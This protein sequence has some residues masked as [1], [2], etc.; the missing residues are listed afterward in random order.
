MLLRHG[1]DYS[2]RHVRRAFVISFTR[3]ILVPVLSRAPGL[4]RGPVARRGI[5]LGIVLGWFVLS[6]VLGYV[7][8]CGFVVVVYH[9]GIAFVSGRVARRGTGLSIALGWFVLRFV[10]GL[11]VRRGLGLVFP[12]GIVLL[13]GPL[14]LGFVIGHIPGCGLRL[15]LAFMS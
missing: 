15:V 8:N 5:G 11:F 13:R 4:A 1:L 9:R 2:S 12:G 6:I 14:F 7:L 10:F 3:Y